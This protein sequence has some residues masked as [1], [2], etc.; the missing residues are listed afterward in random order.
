MGGEHRRRR[1]LARAIGLTLGSAVAWGLAHLCSGHR[2]TGLTL[3]LLYLALLTGGSLSLAALRPVLPALAVQPVWLTGAAV[4]CTLVGAFWAGVVLRSYQLVRPAGLTGLRRL[5]AGGCVGA[6]CLLL[7]APFAF[8][9]RFAYV[10]REVVLSLFDEPGAAVPWPD[11]SR[12][13]ILLI[14]ADAAAGR[15]GARTDS[16]TV[17]SIDL[18]TGRTVLFGLPRNLQRV[19]MP[20]GPARARFPHGFTGADPAT[21]GLLNE[22]F[23]YAED[24]P[25]V[26]PGTVAGQRGPLFL[27]RTV[28]GI[29]GI[30]VD[31]YV[32]VDMLGFKEF[33]DA[34]GGVTVT[35]KRDI[36]YGKRNQGLLPAGTRHL[37]GEAALWFGRSRTDSDDYTRMA[38][39][40]CL[41]HAIAAQADPAAVLRGFERIATAA[42]RYVSTDI[43]QHALPALVELGQKIREA[44]IESLQFTPPL[45]DTAAPDWAL[46]RRRVAQALRPPVSPAPVRRAGAPAPT[47]GTP[48]PVD[49]SL[50]SPTPSGAVDLGAYC[51]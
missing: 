32:M 17:A 46:I 23:Q 49:V 48:W 22:V 26:V 11:R 27:K 44:G 39:Q 10:S 5:L 43:P 2:R 29:L 42:K 34:I 36:R 45:I 31:H 18:T 47:A 14:G 3:L 38:R 12:V 16:M 25:E 6:L 51:A 15:P 24:H 13:N 30:P 50:S 37:D 19:P 4:A 20:P 28:S 1:R 40:K 41:L 35:I 21:P 9:A 8:A 7:F 33:I